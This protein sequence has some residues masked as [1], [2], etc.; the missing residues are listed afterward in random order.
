MGYTSEERENLVESI[1]GV[2]EE[3]NRAR[4]EEDQ[5]GAMGLQSFRDMLNK[6]PDEELVQYWHDWVGERL[7]S[8]DQFHDQVE[9]QFEKTLEGE[10]DYGFC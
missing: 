6:L 8:R 10:E 4:P 2:R 5:L 7:C 9:E 1:M 3:E